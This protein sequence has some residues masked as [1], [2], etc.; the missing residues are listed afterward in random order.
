MGL[1][2][3]MSSPIEDPRLEQYQPMVRAMAKRA[4]R[5]GLRFWHDYE[6]VVQV[7][8]EALWE[9][10]ERF[11]PEFGVKFSTYARVC[12]DSAF[13]NASKHLKRGVRRGVRHEVSLDAPLPSG[14]PMIE[15]KHEGP[16]ALRLLLELEKQ[17][18]VRESLAR[19]SERD[20]FVLLQRVEEGRSLMEVGR[21]LRM[22]REGA[23]Q[24]ERAALLR[25]RAMLLCNYADIDRKQGK[26]RISA[27]YQGSM[28]GKVARIRRS[29]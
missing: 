3:E 21:D 16:S 24:I 25:L 13:I 4:H 19:L 28:R 23:R 29:A 8:M 2:K 9:A 27:G 7:G 11:N 5:Y 18:H 1:G 17:Q 12:I 15:P 6:D 14:D 26:G 10:T 20:R 22:T